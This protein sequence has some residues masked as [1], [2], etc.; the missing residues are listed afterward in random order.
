MRRIVCFLF[1]FGSLLPFFGQQRDAA[2]DSTEVYK[3]IEDYSEKRTFTKR[4]HKLI[5]RPTDKDSQRKS[6]DQRN[7]ANYKPFEG[8]IIRKITIRTNDP[9]GFS[10]LD[11]IQRAKSGLVKF[12]NRVHIKSNKSAIQK[13]LLIHENQPLDSLLAIETARL[14]RA[15]RFIREV[16]ILPKEVSHTK[17]SVDIVITTLDTWSII[18]DASLSSSQTKLKLTEYN[19]IGTGHQLDLGFSKRHSDGDVGY[20]TIYSIP[21]FKNTFVSATAKYIAEYD[22]HYKRSVTIDREFYSPLTRWAGGFFLE[23]RFLARNMPL[24]NMDIE[25]QD[26]AYFAQDYWGGYALPIFPGFSEHERTTNLIFSA[27]ALFVNYRKTPEEK[28]NVNHF[29]SDEKFLL[30]SIGIASRQFV[31]DRYIFQDGVTEDV[32]VGTVYSITG[33]IQRKNH[34]NRPYLGARAS[35]GNY[36][37]IG[38]L[39]LNF[40][41]DTFF[42]KS[43]TEQTTY[44]F[45]ANYFS[46]LIQLK[47]RWKMRQFVK[48]QIVIGTNRWDS[49]ADRLSLNEEP[50]FTG[51]HGSRYDEYNP[52]SIRGFDSPVFGTKKYVLE[53]QTQFYSPWVWLGFRFNPYVNVTVAMLTDTNDNFGNYQVFSS[54]GLGCIFRND[55]LVFNTFQVSF[56]YYP[57]IPGQ[58]RNQFKPNVFRTD[59]FGFQ[60]FQISKPRTVLYR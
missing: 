24:K 20:R 15:K 6:N 40:E 52:G 25:K 4:I 57:N 26:I 58:G 55:Y 33:G 31:E 21:N 43:K 1:A 41:V 37:S 50:Y 19:F 44:S 49:P 47:E 12:G 32:P 5:F 23:D 46:H 10:F 51:I 45:Q 59:D 39:S 35:Y 22:N 27:R 13:Y 11:S 2:Q 9:F 7:P 34:Q 36:F 30:G 18:P 28:H 8:K 60:E 14:L 16:E 53:T 56:A 54:I 38:F 48:P 29:F 17:D 42:N 3:K